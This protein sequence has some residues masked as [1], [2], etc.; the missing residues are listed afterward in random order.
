M[1]HPGHPGLVAGRYSAAEYVGRP[2]VTKEVMGE[3]GKH[4]IMVVES[5]KGGAQRWRGVER[6]RCIIQFYEQVDGHFVARLPRSH[7]NVSHGERDWQCQ[8]HFLNS[9]AA[10]RLIVINHQGLSAGKTADTG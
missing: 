7:G 6:Y 10:I 5:M 3:E 2:A 4:R 1:R 9:E 8:K